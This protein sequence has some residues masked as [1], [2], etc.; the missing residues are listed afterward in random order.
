LSPLS[1]HQVYSELL[2]DAAKCDVNSV[3]NDRIGHAGLI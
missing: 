3:E 2:T 1:Q